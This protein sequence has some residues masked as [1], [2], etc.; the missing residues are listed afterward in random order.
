MA[1]VLFQES[2]LMETFKIPQRE[3]INFFR[4]LEANYGSNVCKYTP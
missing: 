2:G 1:Y 3:F 4:V